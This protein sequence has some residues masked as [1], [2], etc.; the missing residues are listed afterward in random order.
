MCPELLCYAGKLGGVR[1][2]DYFAADRPQ[3]WLTDQV[4]GPLLTCTILLKGFAGWLACLQILLG[5]DQGWRKLKLSPMLLGATAAMVAPRCE[6][7]V[8]LQLQMLPR[9]STVGA[10][11]VEAGG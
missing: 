4:A 6:A 11:L 8:V 7:Q 9:L 10:L 2:R 1:R 3:E 5:G